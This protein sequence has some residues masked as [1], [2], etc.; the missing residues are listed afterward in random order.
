MKPK[1]NIFYYNG[2]KPDINNNRRKFGKSQI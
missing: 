2:V 1:Q